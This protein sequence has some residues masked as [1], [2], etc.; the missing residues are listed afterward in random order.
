GWW[1]AL[2]L[3][4][5]FGCGHATLVSNYLERINRETFQAPPPAVES[6][7]ITLGVAADGRTWLR[8]TEE[9]IARGD[10]RFDRTQIDGGSEGREVF[11][12]SAWSWWLEALCRVRA[13]RTGEALPRA[14]EAASVWAQLPVWLAM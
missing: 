11:W 4:I 10:W 14:I 7:D 1:I 5:G 3:A 6:R 13:V 9:R 8:L 12:S 2:D